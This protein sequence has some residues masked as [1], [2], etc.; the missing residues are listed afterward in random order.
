MKPV[1]IQNVKVG[2][3]FVV[4]GS[5]GHSVMVVD[6]AENSQ[7]QKVFL[8]AQSYMPA[9]DMHILKNHHHPGEG[10]WYSAEFE[11]KL[12]TPE[13]HFERTDLK[14]FADQ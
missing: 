14:R 3:A 2:D 7:G 12:I 6:V 8:L 9:Q 4:G 10:P 13:W 1:D 5:P 11:G